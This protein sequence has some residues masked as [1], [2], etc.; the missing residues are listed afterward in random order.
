VSNLVADE[1]AYKLGGS[2]DFKASGTVGRL[3][4]ELLGSGEID[5]RELVANDVYVEIAGSGHADV[6]AKESLEAVVSGSGDIRYYGDPAH[7]STSVTGSGTCR[8]GR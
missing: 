8:R 7:K 1:F 5:T 2:A 3:D 4:L 6:F